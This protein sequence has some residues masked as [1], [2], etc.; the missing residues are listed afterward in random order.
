MNKSWRQEEL[1]KLVKFRSGGTPAKTVQEYWGGNIPWIT[2]KDLKS[3]YLG[4]SL[5]KITAVG[6]RNGTRIA[7]KGSILLLVRGMTLKKDVPLA[8]ATRDV[9]FNQDV[10]A[11]ET[12]SINNA[13][14]GYFLVSRKSNLMQL[15]NEAGHGTGRLQTD[16]LESFPILVPPAIEQD[17]IASILGTWDRAISLTERLIAA[18]LTLRKV[19][20]QQLLTGKRRFPGFSEPWREVRLGEVLHEVRRPVEW[21]EDATY[22]LASVRRG[23]QGLFHRATKQGRGIKTKDLHTIHTDDFLISKRQVVHGATGLVTPNFD[24]AKVSSS[25]T[26]LRARDSQVLDIEFFSWLAKLPRMVWKTYI[27]SNGVHIEKLFFVV[28]DYLKQKIHLPGEVG[29]QRRIVELLSEADRELSVLRS[30]LAALKTQKRGLM[31]QLLTGKVRV[32]V[33]DAA[34]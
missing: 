28:E 6:A 33:A 34:A 22:R 26:I 18:K 2:A 14:L 27:T 11:L 15:V 13:Y 19:L 5:I 4:D 10:K 3:F 1:G 25:Y 32:Q 12:S 30:Q 20:M 24:G 7:K 16:L 31:Q 23:S 9:A 17:R 21:D 29:E 8:I